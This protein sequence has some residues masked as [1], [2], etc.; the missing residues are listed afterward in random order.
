MP[1]DDSPRRVLLRL[2][3]PQA[4][5]L[6]ATSSPHWMMGHRSLPIIQYA[7]S[8]ALRH[9]PGRSVTP[10]PSPLAMWHY[11]MLVTEDVPAPMDS[12]F[13]AMSL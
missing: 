1:P 6:G 5:T 10:A 4:Y 2:D 12:G 11:R 8:E 9:H 13:A 7:S 3:G